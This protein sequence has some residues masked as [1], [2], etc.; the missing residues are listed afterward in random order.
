MKILDIVDMW[1]NGEMAGAATALR[2]ASHSE[3]VKF[4]SLI[5]SDFTTDMQTF[6]F[7]AQLEE[8]LKD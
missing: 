6:R 2:E 5:V 1:D 3:L 4:I 8:M 7:L